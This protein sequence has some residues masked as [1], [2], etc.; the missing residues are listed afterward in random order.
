M[1]TGCKRKRVRELRRVIP[2]CLM[3]VILGVGATWTFLPEKRLREH[4]LIA[5]AQFS[6]RVVE[7][8]NYRKHL[9]EYLISKMNACAPNLA[10]LIGV[11]CPCV[12]HV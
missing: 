9:H 8:A 2:P 11:C 7:L 1:H 5:R 10:A 6:T 3:V 12:L 4:L